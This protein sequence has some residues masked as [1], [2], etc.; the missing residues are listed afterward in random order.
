MG[1]TF[2][3]M[4]QTCTSKHE[5]GNPISRDGPVASLFTPRELVELSWMITF[6]TSTIVNTLGI[7]AMVH[8][9]QSHMRAEMLI[10]ANAV[11]KVMGRGGGNLANISK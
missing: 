7:M 3:G 4:L 2:D 6:V 11:G 10:P 8:I 5:V 9:H 1:R